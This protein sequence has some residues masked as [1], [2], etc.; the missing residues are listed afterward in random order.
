MPKISVIIPLYNKAP[1]IQRALDSVLAQTERDFEVVVVDDGSTDGSGA[2]AKSY[3]DPRI[4]CVRQENSGVSAARNSGIEAARADLVAFLDADDEYKP[5]FLE[6]ILR[7]RGRFPHAGA[8][9]TAYEIKEPG[10]RPRLPSFA[11]IPPAPWEGIIPNYFRTLLFCSPAW[12]SATAVP[13]S[14]FQEVG[15]FPVGVIEGEDLDL[16]IRIALKH[17]MAFSQAAGAIYH[18]DAAQR[19]AKGAAQGSELRFVATARQALAGGGVPAAAR[20]YLKELIE[21][22][23]LER[24]SACVLAGER[25]KAKELLRACHTS[26]FRGRKLWWSFLAALPP[27]LA[28]AC[29]VVKTRILN[30]G[31]L[32]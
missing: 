13:K 14:V 17:A 10:A 25:A 1:S 29:F 18:L 23:R 6:T 30:R 7:L 22:Q 27:A 16:W 8:Y 4:R 20:P 9:S 24:A 26:E 11:H 15:A 2:I 3:M 28:K 19:A 31:A 32:K 5:G 21:V 12:S